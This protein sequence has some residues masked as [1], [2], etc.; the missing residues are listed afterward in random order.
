M[1][2]LLKQRAA[3]SGLNATGKE[4]TTLLAVLA[5]LETAFV[6]FDPRTA[7]SAPHGAAKK[8]EEAYADL[9]SATGKA[10]RLDLEALKSEDALV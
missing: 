8:A 5:K 10:V 1:E 2:K 9:A 4:L 3:K 7:S 6:S